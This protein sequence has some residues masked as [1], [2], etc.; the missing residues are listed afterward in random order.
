MLHHKTNN[1]NKV[2]IGVG[3]V[4]IALLA[5]LAVE[6]EFDSTSEVAEET[7]IEEN[8]LVVENELVDDNSE[9]AMNL[10]EA[11]DAPPF[12]EIEALR[13][14]VP[15]MY[16]FKRLA[17]ETAPFITYLPEE[18]EG[19]FTYDEEEGITIG[20]FST[21]ESDFYREVTLTYVE[22]PLTEE[23]FHTYHEEIRKN[24]VGGEVNVSELNEDDWTDYHI[25]TWSEDGWSSSTYISS[26]KDNHVV[27][28][29]SFPSMG[30]EEWGNRERNSLVNEWIWTDT[31]EKLR[32]L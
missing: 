26:H 25:W 23:V 11:H 7:Y 32:P 3:V 4:T 20:A 10:E 22:E 1:R 6:K 21:N 12:Q 27:I 8:L 13:D 14:G 9:N 5:G 18:Y 31:G 30:S 17:P 28:H 16:T 29:G 15:I 19:E 24:N 2:V